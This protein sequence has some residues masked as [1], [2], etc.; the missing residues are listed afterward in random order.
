MLPPK[1]SA[2]KWQRYWYLR[3]YRENRFPV[4]LQ[5]RRDADPHNLLIEQVRSW[6][7]LRTIDLVRVDVDG[8]RRLAIGVPAVKQGALDRLSYLNS[9]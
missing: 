6:E 7:L 3:P 4:P 2:T 9:L 1:R 5:A 8:Y